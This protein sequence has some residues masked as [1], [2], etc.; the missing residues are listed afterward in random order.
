MEISSEHGHNADDEDIDID[1]DFTTGQTDEDYILEDAEPHGDFDNGLQHNSLNVNNDDLMVDDDDRSYVMDDADVE[2]EN[3]RMESDIIE[4]PYAAEEPTI[5]PFSGM[6]TEGLLQLATDTPVQNQNLPWEHTQHVEGSGS[7]SAAEPGVEV[8]DSHDTFHTEKEIVSDEP[9]LKVVEVSEEAVAEQPEESLPADPTSE[10]VNERPT[11]TEEPLIEITSSADNKEAVG[12][13]E[14]DQTVT[15]SNTEVEREDKGPYE[16]D[17][18]LSLALS[19]VVVYQAT[20][21]ALFSTSEN[22]D[23]DSYFLSDISILRKPLSTFFASIRHI[24]QD[25]LS[26]EDELCL[27]VEVLGLETDEVMFKTNYRS[28]MANLSGTDIRGFDERRDTWTDS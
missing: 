25:D 15:S 23:P 3:A 17:A 10:P 12:V 2:P 9:L 5:N 18:E 27:T 21:Y 20:E 4:M 22:E 7:L 24:I 16:V 28:F 6:D 1:I 13:P 11:S 8:G 14:T 26:G 19:I